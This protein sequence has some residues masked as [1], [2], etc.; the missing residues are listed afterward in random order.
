MTSL[1]TISNSKMDSISKVIEVDTVVLKDTIFQTLTDTVTQTVTSIDTVIKE[2][3]QQNDSL[4]FVSENADRDIPFLL[5]FGLLFLA[6][7]IFV[8]FKVLGDYVTPF[9]KSKYRIK[10]AFLFVYRLKIITWFLFTLFSF[11]QIVSSHLWIGIS[12]T[13][14]II[15]LGI[16]FW[17]DFFVGIYHKFDGNMNIGDLISVGE[18]SGKIQKF[19]TRYI[20]LEADNDEVILLPYSQLLNQPISKKFGQGEVRSKKLLLSIDQGHPKN[21]L[22]NVQQ[23]VYTCPWVYNH[24]PIKIIQLSDSQ[25]EI[26]VYASDAYTFNKIEQY[27]MNYYK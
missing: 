10:R 18:V 2:V 9:L 15:L 17:K 1:D 11:Y 6:G 22:K 25:Y 8:T 14:F 27:L 26:T 20:K 24:K 19:N 23:V 12:L 13:I 4:Q 16:N 5:I 3:P 7:V 21:N